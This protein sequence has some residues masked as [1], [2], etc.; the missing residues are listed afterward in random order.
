MG[1]SQQ[2]GIATARIHLF[3]SQLHCSGRGSSRLNDKQLRDTVESEFY[4][5]QE[6]SICKSER[7][8]APTVKGM[9]RHEAA[10]VGEFVYDNLHELWWLS[11]TSRIGNEIYA[12]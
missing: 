1:H 10:E 3:A 9:T 4:K 5:F 11:H 8:W 7:H 12:R 6:H 2:D